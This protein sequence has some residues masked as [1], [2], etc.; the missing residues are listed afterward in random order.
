MGFKTKKD[1]LSNIERYKVRLVAKWF[2]QKEGVDYMETFSLVSKKDS[3]HII[4]ALVAHF[5]LELQQTD[6]KTTFLNGELEEKVYMKQ[7]EG[8]P[9][10]DENVMDQCIYLK[11]SGS[12][13]CFLVLYV[14]DILLATNDKGLLHEIQGILGLSQ[15]TYINKVLERFRMKDCSPSVSPIANGDRSDIILVVGMLGRYQVTQVW[16]TGK[17][18]IKVMRYLQG[19]EDYKLM[20]KRTSN[21]E[22]IRLKVWIKWENV[23]NYMFT[24]IHHFEVVQHLTTSSTNHLMSLRL[25]SMFY[26]LLM[27]GKSET[28]WFHDAGT[29]DALTK[30]GGPNGSIRNPQELNHSANRGLKTAVDL[31]GAEHLRSVF[32]RMGLED[33][34]I[35]A[36]SGAHTLGHI[37][38]FQAFDGKWT[39]EPWKFDNSYFK[40]LMKSSTKSLTTSNPPTGYSQQKPSS[41]AAGEDSTGRQAIVIFSTDQALIKD[42]K[43]L[44][45]VSC[46]TRIWR[47]SSEIMRHPQ[48]AFGAKELAFATTAIAITF[49]YRRRKSK[50]TGVKQDRSELFP[51]ST[52]FFPVSVA[53]PRL[54]Q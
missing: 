24:H 53:E 37:S 23:I 32:N 9:S 43:F 6:V 31:C 4:L 46:M 47:L 34:D 54:Q 8:F 41:S 10:S 26:K 13:V 48:A 40:E 30:T 51:V 50:G 29:Y 15:E 28:T 42:P 27:C 19:T 45:Y 35:V 39:E 12:K 36:L 21:L 44:E 17:L 49:Y 20:C 11:V 2:T 25:R 14:D 52:V 7:P 38:K 22:D 18:Q 33:N 1:S 16:T 3:L 5:D